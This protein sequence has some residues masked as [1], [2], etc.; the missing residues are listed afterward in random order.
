MKKVL[1]LLLLIITLFS[2]GVNSLAE[3]GSGSITIANTTKGETYKLYKVFDATLTRTDDNVFIS[4]TYNGKLPDD[5]LYFQ[6]D[7][8]GNISILPAGAESTDGKYLSQG[9]IEF[10]GTIKGNPIQEVIAETNS[11]TFP[12]LPYGYYYIESSLK[13]KAVSVDSTTPYAVIIDKN[14]VP[15]W[16]DPEGKVELGKYIV[17]ADGK[18]V[19]ENSVG[20]GDTVKFEISFNATDYILTDKVFAYYLTDTIDPGFDIDQ[21]SLR[22]FFDGLEKTE[23]TDYSVRWTN[24]D[25]TFTVSA[26]W[27]NDDGSSKYEANVVMKVTYNATLNE[28]AVIASPGNFNKTWFDYRKIGETPHDPLVPEDDPYDPFT[29]PGTPYHISPEK[30]T[31]TFTYA[32][33]LTKIDGKNQQPISGAEFTLTKGTTSVKA[34]ETTA[35]GVYEY[36]ADGTVSTFKTDASGVLVI[37]GLEEGA[38]KLKETK[39]PDGYLLAV[40]SAEFELKKADIA[41]YKAEHTVYFDEDGN[42]TTA[43]TDKEVYTNYLVNVLG[44]VFKNIPGKEL[45]STG[46]IGTTVFYVIGGALVLAA[47]ILLICKKRNNTAR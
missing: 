3:D 2:L 29:P 36:D 26:P 15:S 44:M 34:K 32:V 13:G 11:I 12:N 1:A 24:S 27:A 41:K 37:K 19:T 8:S 16:D 20:F 28:N 33:G 45:P 9:A 40:N 21:T 14:Q 46:G 39:A 7:A 31:V 25:R 42:E 5:N 6:Q 10:L 4:Y 35:P 23:N 17:L 30:K 18:K 22:V 43:K 38:Y 47:G